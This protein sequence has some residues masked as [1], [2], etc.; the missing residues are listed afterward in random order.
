MSTIN[1]IVT[2]LEAIATNHEQINT[3]GFGQMP[4]F[5]KSTPIVYPVMWVV[6][7]P[8]SI[9][10]ND[11]VLKYQFLFADLVHKDL[12]NETE[13]SS[14][15]MLTA[16][17]VIGQLQHPDYEWFYDS[18]SDLQPVYAKLDDEITGWEITCSLTINSPYNRCAIPFSTA[19]LPE[20]ESG[21]VTIFDTDGV[22]VVDYVS[23]NSY[24]VLTGGGGCGGDYE[25]YVNGNLDQSGTS[26]DLTIETFNIT[27]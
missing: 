11:L 12:S 24:Y 9:N 15:Q 25:I 3:F 4:E 26:V 16:L 13:V 22:T 2:Q 6:Q 18:Q 23:N 14:D 5:G 27:A 8:S 19:P 7:L 1:Q 10:G 20:N 21:F 17:D